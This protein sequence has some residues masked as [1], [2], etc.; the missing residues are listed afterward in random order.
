MLMFGKSERVSMRSERKKVGISAESSRRGFL[1]RI[2]SVHKGGKKELYIDVDG[3]ASGRGVYVC[4]N[5]DCIKSLKKSRRLEKLFSQSF[6]EKM[7]EK[8][9]EVVSKGE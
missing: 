4:K 5:I 2:A 8:L 7:Y 3:R 6:S 1:L 9:E